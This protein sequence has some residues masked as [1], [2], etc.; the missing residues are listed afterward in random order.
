MTAKGDTTKTKYAADKLEK[1][2]Q[3]AK[4]MGGTSFVSAVQA[5]GSVYDDHDMFGPIM[6]SV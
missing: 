1:I 5:M 2:T 3:Q 6:E 4:A